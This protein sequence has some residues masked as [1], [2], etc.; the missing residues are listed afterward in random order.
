MPDYKL[1]KIYK[2]ISN[3]TDKIYIG[4][5]TEKY[6]SQRQVSHTRAYKSFLNGKDHFRASYDILKF[7]DAKII[8][9]ETFPC[10]NKYELIAR[11]QY[12][13]EQFKDTCVNY[14]NAF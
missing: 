9:I 14:C 1:G 7:P 12:W 8:L 11:E 3:Q 2:I 6:L 13:I 5:T 10:N 4:S